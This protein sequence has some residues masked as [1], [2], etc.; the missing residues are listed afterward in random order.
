MGVY[1]S[2]LVMKRRAIA[3][4]FT[5][6]KHFEGSRIQGPF[7]KELRGQN[8]DVSFGISSDLAAVFQK[9]T[10]VWSPGRY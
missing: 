9:E 5:N 3:E 4:A 8:S 7:L 2:F 10:E 6:H 1:V